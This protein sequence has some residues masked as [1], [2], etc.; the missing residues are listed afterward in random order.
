MVSHSLVRARDIFLCIYFLPKA[1]LFKSLDTLAMEKALIYYTRCSWLNLV[2]FIMSITG[3]PTWNECHR[4]NLKRQSNWIR[5]V[6]M[7]DVTGAQYQLLCNVKLMYCLVSHS[8]SDLRR[9][10][11]LTDCLAGFVFFDLQKHAARSGVHHCERSEREMGDSLRCCHAT[12]KLRASLLT[13]PRFDLRTPPSY[14]DG[15]LFFFSSHRSVKYH[16]FISSK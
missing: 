4:Q 10:N 2:W 11:T 7:I 15:F 6:E 8:Q 5:H 12:R 13:A 9:F 16:L 3:W 14:P 1:I